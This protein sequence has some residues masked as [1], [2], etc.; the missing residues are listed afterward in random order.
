[1]LVDNR[2]YGSIAGQDQFCVI[3]EVE[4]YTISYFARTVWSE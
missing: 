4:L 3:V 1:V 2:Y